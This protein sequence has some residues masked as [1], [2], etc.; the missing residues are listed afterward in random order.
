MCAVLITHIYIIFLPLYI[1]EE[2]FFDLMF[3]CVDIVGRFKSDA[4]LFNI[5]GP[6][7][8]RRFWPVLLLRKGTFSLN[9]DLRAIRLW[10][11]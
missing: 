2:L 7:Q 3:K 6:W 10:S 1:Y 4:R 11:A 8:D 9:L 5:F